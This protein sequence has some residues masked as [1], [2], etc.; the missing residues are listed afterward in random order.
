MLT[1]GGASSMAK[2]ATRGRSPSALPKRD[3]DRDDTHMPIPIGKRRSNV[4]DVLQAETVATFPTTSICVADG[5]EG[6]SLR[7]EHHTSRIFGVTINWAHGSS[8]D[9]PDVS[10]RRSIRN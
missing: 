4:R 6:R 9:L 1:D 5:L 7:A 10:R 3:Y 2:V 8:K